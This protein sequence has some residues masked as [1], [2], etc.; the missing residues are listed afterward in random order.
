MRQELPVSRFFACA[1]AAIKGEYF[2]IQR[3]SVAWSTLTPRSANIS[4]R[5]RSR[6]HTG[7]RKTLHGGSY[8]S[9]NASLQKQPSFRPFPVRRHS[10][11]QCYISISEKRPKSFA[12]EPFLNS[13]SWQGPTSDWFDPAAEHTSCCHRP[14]HCVF[15]LKCIQILHLTGPEGVTK[16][17]DRAIVADFQIYLTSYL[18]GELR[19][20]RGE[21]GTG[22][23][24]P[25]QVLEVGGQTLAITQTPDG[26]RV[27]VAAL[28]GSD[29]TSAP[30]YSAFQV[31]PV[32]GVLTHL[33][34][35]PAPAYMVHISM[36]ATGCFLLG[37]SEPT[38]RVSVTPIGSDGVPDTTPSDVIQGLQRPHHILVGPRN[39]FCYV[40][41]M[42]TDNVLRIG[43]D[44]QT[45][46]FDHDYVADLSVAAGDGPR[47]M[48]HHPSGKWAYLVTQH[49]G[50]I[51][52]CSFD[53]GSGKLRKIG[54]VSI[55]DKGFTGSPRAAQIR[56]TPDG[57]FLFVSERTG[58]TIVSWRIDASDGSLSDR[59]ITSSPVGMRCFDIDPSGR[60]L[61][62]SG[63]NSDRAKS[64]EDTSN[65][66]CYTIN[67][68]TGALSNPKFWI[69]WMEYIGSK[70]PSDPSRTIAR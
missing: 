36:D 8:L 59:R 50:R 66:A 26:S 69:V 45:G 53:P 24:C 6:L 5:L 23:L 55:L 41:C 16:M 25:E 22:R 30:L 37:A 7:F 29:K 57:Q 13:P 18:T 31:D 11:N 62:V 21:S 34:T 27:Y 35:V 65:V 2:T 33:G 46:R 64:P 1:F 14:P 4:S 9:D 51:V 28:A 12:T 56:I 47:H 17:T 63:V 68:K 70:S 15:L 60:F 52:T 19:R 61:V 40:P 3:F 38:G 39:L 44:P 20:F 58:K 49:T 32:D 48:A 67:G 43:F 54:A 42:H 10:E